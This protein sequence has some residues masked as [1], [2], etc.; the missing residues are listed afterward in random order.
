LEFL[1]NQSKLKGKIAA[2]CAWN[3]FDRILNQERSGLPVISAFDP[4]G[5]I[6]PTGNEKLINAMMKDSHKPWGE[7]E[8]LDVFTHYGAMEYMKTKKP[9]VLYIAYG[10][11]D[12]WAHS[13][14]YRSYLDAGRQIDEWVKNIWNFVQTDPQY[15]NKTTLLITTDHGRGD[16]VKDEWTSHNNKIE[17]ASEIWFAAMGPDSPVRGEIKDDVQLY[18][19][20]LA[21]SIARLMGYT[22]EAKHPVASE[23]FYLFKM[24]K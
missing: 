14:Q 19:Q 23:I 1:N 8:C 10:E 4:V 20:Q 9:R 2:F 3:A 16:L 18:Q 7:D 21:Q 22:F 15:K 13:G 5:G 12:E 24:R 11:T 6:K 17:G